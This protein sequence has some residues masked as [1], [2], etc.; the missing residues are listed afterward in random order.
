[1]QNG[2]QK[3]TLVEMNLGVI[4]RCFSRT[5]DQVD[6]QV[7]QIHQLVEKLTVVREGAPIHRI[8]VVIPI[9]HKFVDVDCGKTKRAL[10]KLPTNIVA[11]VRETQVDIFSGAINEAAAWQLSRGCT[12]TLVLSSSCGSLVS[13][14]NLTALIEPLEGDALATGL[15]LPDPTLGEFIKRGCITNTFAIWELNSFFAVGGLD[16]SLHNRYKDERLNKYVRGPEGP[17]P[18]TGL[19][20]PT[21]ARLI[22][23][24]G[25]CVAPVFPITGGEWKRPDPQTDPDG[26][27][28]EEAKM[29]SKAERHYAI[30]ARYGFSLSY[31]ESGILPGYPK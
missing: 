26:A 1:M 13:T 30:A 16:L 28:R 19:E 23:C 17:I 18:I 2:F 9:N 21:V 20:I 8:D 7:K 10:G 14:E 24:Y 25:P 4:L 27:A 22:E 29:R 6:S 31:I 15:V 12:H 11:T 5:P 3:G